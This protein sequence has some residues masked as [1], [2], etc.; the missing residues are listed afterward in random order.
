MRRTPRML[1]GSLL[2]AG[3][4][5]AAG[6]LSPSAGATEAASSSA[7]QTASETAATTAAEQERVRDLWTPER[8]RAAVP[9]EELAPDAVRKAVEET[10]SAPVSQGEARTVAPTS[11]QQAPGASAFPE[12]GAPWTDGGAVENT[13]GRVFFTYDGRAASC[14]GN[15]VTSE[16]GS[17]VMTAGH[18]VKMDGNW[19]TDWQFVPG[20]AD[21]EAPHGEWP[22]ESTHA[23]PQ[24][25]A[26]EDMNYDVGAAVVGEL[27]GQ[28]LTDVVGGQG[29]AFNTGY[30]IDVYAFGYPAA[31]PYDG[32]SLTYCSGTTF[33][34]PLLTT[35]HGLACDMTGGSSGG[36]WFTDF[37]ES[38]GEGL[39]SSVNSFGYVFLPDNMFGPHFGDDAEALYE[40]A[41]TT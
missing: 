35:T 32:E 3:T 39:Q 2:A 29:L 4:L 8:M 16:N 1:F 28:Q 10:R 26:S 27:D 6:A 19:H 41:Q 24:W 37:D 22:A 38:T 23:T 25:D 12:G 31:D 21:G 36:P 30:E 18:C 5:L 17:T 40:T 34:D 15:A 11:G 14:S 20:Y 13:T 7:G 33:E 9:I